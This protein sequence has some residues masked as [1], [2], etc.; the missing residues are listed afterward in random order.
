MRGAAALAPGAPQEGL[1]AGLGRGLGRE[2]VARVDPARATAQVE[3]D[4]ALPSLALDQPGVLFQ[5]AQP[6]APRSVAEVEPIRDHDR[7]RQGAAAGVRRGD[8]AAL[9]TDLDLD[10]R[11]APIQ[12]GVVLT[13]REAKAGRAEVSGALAQGRRPLD[14]HTWRGG[15]RARAEE[16]EQRQGQ[17][18]G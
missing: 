9:R 2:Q 15:G 13:L 18:Q 10:P 3:A 17:E 1:R 12:G 11:A 16:A 14:P 6:S 4:P 8:P 7:G 5:L